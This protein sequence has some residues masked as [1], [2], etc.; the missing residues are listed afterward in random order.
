[1]ASLNFSMKGIYSYSPKVTM[2]GIYSCSPLIMIDNEIIKLIMKS[3]EKL[4]KLIVIWPNIMLH[5]K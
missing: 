4:V 1:M 2:K 3:F 5:F